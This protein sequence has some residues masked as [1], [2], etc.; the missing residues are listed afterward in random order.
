MPD[1][2]N[3]GAFIQAYNAQIAV[4]EHAQIIVAATVVQASNDVRQ[5]VPMAAKIVENVGR[6]AD[7]TSADTG[8]FSAQNVEHPAF[9]QTNLLVPP[10][11]Q[12]AER[13]S[14]TEVSSAAAQMR[15]KLSSVAN[16]AL[17]KQR[18][19]IVEP[20]FGQIKGARGLRQLLLRGLDAA[21][22]EFNFIALTHNVL[23]LFRHGARPALA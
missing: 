17:Y 18:K 13:M 5:L 1:G 12:K 23:K 20:V 2:A 22:A 3:K 10:P 21:C 15:A 4:D 14:V 16:G 11:P 8:Y 7:T 19:A 6:L 9:A